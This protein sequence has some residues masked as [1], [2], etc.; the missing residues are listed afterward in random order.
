MKKNILYINP[1]HTP[2]E[3]ISHVGNISEKIS[4]EI[5]FLEFAEN[6][7]KK[8]IEIYQKHNYD[9]IWIIYGP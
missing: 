6:F 7:P 1:L 4:L 8:I 2:I 5:P 3:I 9:E